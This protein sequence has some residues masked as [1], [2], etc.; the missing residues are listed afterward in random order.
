M[1]RFGISAKLLLFSAIIFAGYAFLA[2]LA[3]HKIHQ[4]ITAERIDMVRHVDEVAVSMV[5][6]AYARFQSGE[7]T[8][9]AAKT[10][11]KDQ[12]RT[13]KYGASGEYYYIHDYEGTC[14]MHGGKP[15]REGQNYIGFVDT[16][17][18][19]IIKEQIEA[20]R[21]GTG[22][23]FALSPVGRAGSNEPVTKLS[24]AI[25]FEP[26][27][28][29]VSTS[30]FVDDIDARYA[31]IAWQFFLIAGLVGL[32]MAVC[33]YWLSRQITRPLDRL[34]QFTEQPLSAAP[35]AAFERDL[36]L[37]DEIGTL[38]R[39]LQGFKERSAEAERL[40]GEVDS[41]KSEAEAARRKTLSDMVTTVET[42]TDNAVTGIDNRMTAMTEAASVMSRSAELVGTSAQTVATASSQALNNAQ[43]VASAAE[44]LSSSIR[45]ISSQVANATKATSAAVNRSESARTTIATLGRSRHAGRPGDDADFG[46][47]FANQ[48][49]CAERD[50]RGGAC[51]RSGP[52]LCGGGERGEVAGDP[53]RAVDGRDQPPDQRNPEH[54]PGNRARHGRGQQH[55]AHDRRNRGLDR[56]RRRR[57][58]CRDH[59]EIS[60]NVTETANGAREVSTRITEVSG[61]ATRLGGEAGRVHSCA[62]DVTDAVS[63]LR[64]VIVTAVTSAAA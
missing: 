3:S 14:V 38:A 52:R 9:E 19:Q 33:A 34:V 64:R 56:R 25:A 45:E 50:H 15:E 57:A 54:H 31:E 63:S 59:R 4:T 43:T 36:R 1:P 51:R 48:P 46:D 22:A 12:L 2:W 39:A 37:K 6:T 13:V 29:V 49:A 20:G 27:H 55:R 17:G 18:R 42:E 8:E 35:S 21:N 30:M 28:W 10:L 11:V 7:L 5:K 32:F 61:E 60:R 47:R 62:A 26:W 41:Q 24:Y 40:R 53:D 23:V 16:N 58:A 44:Q